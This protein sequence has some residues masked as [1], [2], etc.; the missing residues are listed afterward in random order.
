MDGPPVLV[1]LIDVI[2][3]V[4]DGGMGCKMRVGVI[5]ALTPADKDMARPYWLGMGAAHAVPAL[6]HGHPGSTPPADTEL[7]V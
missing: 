6:R 5:P 7:G 4:D 3:D 2:L 1:L